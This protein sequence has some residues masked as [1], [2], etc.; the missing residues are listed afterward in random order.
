MLRNSYQCYLLFSLLISAINYLPSISTSEEV[1]IN[2]TEQDIKNL[3]EA[4]NRT[5][6]AILGTGPAG[7]SAAIFSARR[8]ID[9]YVFQ[10]KNHLGYLKEGLSVENIPGATADSGINVMKK[11][12]EQARHFGA[13]FIDDTIEKIDFSVWPRKLYGAKDVYSA[14]AV[15]ATTGAKSKTLGIEGE[16]EYTYKGI[17]T[18]GLCDAHLAKDQD[19][20]IIGGGDCAAERVFQL[21]PYAKSITLLV[22]SNEMKAIPTM[23]MKIKEMPKVKILYNKEAVEFVGDGKHL[24]GLK[25]LD[26]KTNT[27][28]FMPARWVFLSIGFVPNTGLFKNHLELDDEGYIR[29]DFATQETSVPMVYAAGNVCDPRYK[30]AATCIGSATQAAFNACK[31]I[32][33]L[34]INREMAEKIKDN[35][36]VLEKVD[37]QHQVPELQNENELKE[38]IKKNKLVLVDFFVSTCP[39]CQRIGTILN[40]LAPK[41]KDKIAFIK[42]EDAKYAELSKQHKIEYVPTLMMF[43]DGLMIDKIEEQL[44]EQQLDQKLT[45][46]ITISSS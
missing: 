18:C 29:V 44:T 34:P 9:T 11:L 16:A 15:I 3:Y 33:R 23:Q 30:L 37:T 43:L 42:V 4:K 31:Y 17:L 28:S 46:A 25:V 38:I 7:L 2:L 14:K 36:F 24:T 5:D 35:V 41:Y 8:G 12:E 22:R 32:T 13:H 40:K 45:N 27:M 19:I 26:K 21:L 1:E 10:G 39:E 20:I 6:L